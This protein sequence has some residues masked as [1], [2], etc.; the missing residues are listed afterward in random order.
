MVVDTGPEGNYPAQ[1]HDGRW[2][3]L[4]RGQKGNCPAGTVSCG[5][6][7]SGKDPNCIS[8]DNQRHFGLL[9]CCPIVDCSASRLEGHWVFQE[10]LPSQ[11]TSYVV[12]M[13]RR[14]SRGHEFSNSNSV[15]ETIS[16]TISREMNL[17]FTPA[18]TG[19]MGG[20]VS[21]GKSMTESESRTVSSSASQSLAVDEEIT[22]TRNVTC[23]HAEDPAVA[24]NIWKFVYEHMGQCDT[25]VVTEHLACIPTVDNQNNSIEPCCI[26]GQNSDIF[27]QSCSNNSTNICEEGGWE[28]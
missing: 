7:S 22:I 2:L 23:H 16:E 8:T 21:R 28:E 15:T 25:S 18:S 13:T 4:H 26:P 5:M 17:A 1:H 14:E 27:H 3:R 9:K 20:G 19:G 6:C 11:T 12:S 10:S 24:F